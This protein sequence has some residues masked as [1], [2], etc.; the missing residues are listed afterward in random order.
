MNCT[1]FHAIVRD[2]LAGNVGAARRT[3]IEEH[4]AHCKECAAYDEIAR[5]IGCLEVTDFLDEYIEE[6]LA[7]ERREIFDR[8]FSICAACKIYLAIYEQAIALAKRAFAESDEAAFEPVPESLV[9]S[10]LA[11]RRTQ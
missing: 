5:E 10:I 1:G 8:H 3:E 7:A 2:Y 6:H 9:I 4:L 11:E